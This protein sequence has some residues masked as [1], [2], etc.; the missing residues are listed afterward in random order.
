MNGVSKYTIFAIVLYSAYT[1]THC[2]HHTIQH[3]IS[4]LYHTHVEWK[5]FTG[6]SFSLVH[7]NKLMWYLVIL[8]H[9]KYL[10]IME[11]IFTIDE[12]GAKREGD[13]GRE[14]EKRKGKN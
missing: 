9:W 12:E 13:R 1:D 2:A 3:A 14:I 8:A 4:S 5:N 6:I 11:N 7:N 10:S